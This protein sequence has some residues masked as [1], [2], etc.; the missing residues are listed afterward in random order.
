MDIGETTKKDDGFKLQVN[1]KI[2][3]IEV[4]AILDGHRSVKINFNSQTN[5]DQIEQILSL[6]QRTIGQHS[7]L[8]KQL[9]GSTEKGKSYVELHGCPDINGTLLES[10][11]EKMPANQGVYSRLQSEQIVHIVQDA[12]KMLSRKNFI[13]AK[14]LGNFEALI[15]EN[16]SALRKVQT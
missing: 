12:L 10:L 7:E 9:S 6:L 13:S 3:S 14:H 16:Q 8:V 11:K 1:E 2:I 15:R 5:G 4:S